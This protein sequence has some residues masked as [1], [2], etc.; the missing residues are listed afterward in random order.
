MDATEMSLMKTL[1]IF[2]TDH[3][4]SLSLTLKVI[5]WKP[6]ERPVLLNDELLLSRPSLLDIHS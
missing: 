5:L 2:A 1:D 3:K 4:V 6:V